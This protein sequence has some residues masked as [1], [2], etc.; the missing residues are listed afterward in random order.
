MKTNYFLASANTCYGFKNCF[1]YINPSLDSY[2]YILKGGPGTGKSTFMKSIGKHFEEKGYGVEYFYCSSDKDSLDGVRII[3]KNVSIV[4]GTAPHTI[5]PT[6]PKVKEEI[7]NLG[8]DINKNIRKHKQSIIN[9]LDK[10]SHHFSLAYKYL[11]TVG[12]LFD[13]E[14]A[15]HTPQLNIDE[16]NKIISSLNTTKKGKRRNLFINFITDNGIEDFIEKNNFKNIINLTSNNYFDNAKLLNNLSQYLDQHN[17]EYTSF[18]SIYNPNIIQ[19]IYIE[20]TGTLYLNSNIKFKNKAMINR[21]VKLAGKNIMRAKYFHKKVEN[22]Y[23]NNMD[24]DHIDKTRD[25]LIRDIEK[26]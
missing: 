3:D 4:D 17:L 10:K 19:A 16:Y 8:E 24:F 23:I 15:L 2:I 9:L 18:L 11:S 26:I 5:D 1:E 13:I 22:Y 7:I 21:L 20:N 12:K 14:S 6:I 25:K